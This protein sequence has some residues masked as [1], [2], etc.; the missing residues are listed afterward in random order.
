MACFTLFGI[1]KFLWASGLS[2]VAKVM[3]ALGVKRMNESR[4]EFRGPV[5]E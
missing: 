5:D 3:G 4:N 2:H 1:R